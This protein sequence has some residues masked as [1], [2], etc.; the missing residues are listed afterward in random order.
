MPEIAHCT[1]TSLC[2]KTP[3]PK[4]TSQSPNQAVTKPSLVRPLS[5]GMLDD[6]AQ[7]DAEFGAEDEMED[8]GLGFM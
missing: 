3:G 4:P 1:T 6:K 5:Q 7:R 2:S 8:D